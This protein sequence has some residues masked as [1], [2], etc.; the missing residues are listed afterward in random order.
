MPIFVLYA[1]AEL[2][3]VVRLTYPFPSCQWKFDVQQSAGSE[4]REGVII[5]PEEEIELAETRNGTANFVS[6]R[7]MKRLHSPFSMPLH[8]GGAMH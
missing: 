8:A 7:R 6:I 4:S 1:K 5:D 2:E 3:G